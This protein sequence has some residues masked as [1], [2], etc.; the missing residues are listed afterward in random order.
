MGK[1]AVYL[2]I[3]GFD[4]MYQNDFDD[5]TLAEMAEALEII[6]QIIPAL[7]RGNQT[8][9]SVALI[10]PKSHHVGSTLTKA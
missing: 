7:K 10:E 3:L 5:P 4:V 9:E 1:L 6:R 2:R 8:A